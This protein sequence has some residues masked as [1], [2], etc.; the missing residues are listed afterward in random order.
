MADKKISQLTALSAA[1]LAPSTD[2]LAI[3]DTS[4]TET[5]KVTAKDLVDGALNAGSANGVVYLNGSKAAT[6]GTALVFDGSNLG[7]GVTPSA[8]FANSKAFQMGPG[9]SLEARTNDATVFSLGANQYINSA[10]N[11]IYLTT[12]VASLYEQN[13]GQHRWYT[14]PSGTAGN[15]ISFTQAMTLDASGNLGVGA[16]SP[17]AS[18]RLTIQGVGTSGNPM[19][20]IIFRQ[21]STDTMYIGSVSTDNNTDVEI[22]N[23]RNGYLRFATNNTE[24]GRFTAGGYFKASNDGTYVDSTGTFHELRGGA[25]NGYT[26]VVSSPV[27]TPSAQY[28]FDIR[29]SA[30]TP[31][32]ATARFLNCTDATATRA[33]IRSNGGLSNYQANDTNLSDERTKKDIAPLGPMWAKIKALEIVTFKY[34]DQTHDDD[35]IGLIAQQVEAVAPEFVDVDGWG[36]T[37]EDG[38]PLKSIYTADMYHAAIKALQEAMARIESLEAKVAALEAK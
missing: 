25:A 35:N 31:N 11:R 14:A 12:N 20:G 27:A 16:T 26:A 24:R 18:H 5:K 33:Y 4:A 3:V 8:W 32:D 13:T 23:P 30:A 1:N 37:P 28:V 17:G 22:F 19:G 6:S 38:V 36:D 10:G 7:L 2:V 29:F 21:G 9:F 34:K 15:T